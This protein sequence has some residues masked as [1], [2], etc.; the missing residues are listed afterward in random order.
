[1]GSQRLIA[2]PFCEN[3][4]TGGFQPNLFTYR[5]ASLCLWGR[6]CTAFSCKLLDVT[7]SRRIVVWLEFHPSGANAERIAYF[8]GTKLKDALSRQTNGDA[9]DQTREQLASKVRALIDSK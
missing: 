6:K 8:L 4:L 1:M 5:T 3:R 9:I 2:L 7:E